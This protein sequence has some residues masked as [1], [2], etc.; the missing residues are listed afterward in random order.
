MNVG[1]TRSPLFISY[2][3]PGVSQV[4]TPTAP[5]HLSSPQWGEGIYFGTPNFTSFAEITGSDH[6]YSNTPL[7]WRYGSEQRS[8]DSTSSSGAGNAGDGAGHAGGADGL[9]APG[10][11]NGGKKKGRHH[12]SAPDLKMQADI[13]VQS[14]IGKYGI[15]ENDHPAVKYV[16]ELASRLFGDDKGV[17]VL[18]TKH[19]DEINS[20][21]LPNRTI[22]LTDRMIQFCEFEE[23]LEYVLS[24][25]GRHIVKK[26]FEQNMELE[27]AAE[28]N[29]SRLLPSVN[30]ELALLGQR[31]REEW[32]SDLG[33]G[34]DM[35]RKRL[36]PYGE[37]VFLMR[38]LKM[39]QGEDDYDMDHGSS[40]DR[41]L[42]FGM[43]ARLYDMAALTTDLT[44]IPEDIRC[45]PLGPARSDF[46]VLVS[47]GVFEAGTRYEIATERH[48]RA[49]EAG[50]ATLLAALPLISD[51][52]EKRYEEGHSSSL[53][54]MLIKEDKIVLER[55]IKKIKLEIDHK[56]PETSTR[57]RTQILVAA[58]IFGSG[59]FIFESSDPRHP[60][61]ALT[62]EFIGTLDS[63]EDFQAFARIVRPETFEKL[64]LYIS[65]DGISEDPKVP[66]YSLKNIVMTALES[67]LFDAGEE[68]LDVD[69][70]LAFCMEWVEHISKLA[71]DRGMIDLIKEKEIISLIL[72][73]KENL[74]KGQEEWAY[75]KKVAEKTSITRIDLKWA[76]FKIYRKRI[77]LDDIPI[78][79]K[80]GAK[81]EEKLIEILGE[82]EDKKYNVQIEQLPGIYNKYIVKKGGIK[83]DVCCM[84]FSDKTFDA[85]VDAI[86]SRKKEDFIAAFMALSIDLMDTVDEH[87]ADFKVNYFLE[88]L[89]ENY[90]FDLSNKE[91]L[92]FLHLIGRFVPDAFLAQRLRKSLLGKMMDKL[93]AAEKFD[94]LFSDR[95]FAPSI[96]FGT[97]KDHMDK[98][99]NTL[100][101]ISR[102][103][104]IVEKV[105]DAPLSA[106]YGKLVVMDSLMEKEKDK[107]RLFEVMMK[108]RESELE[109][110]ESLFANKKREYRI[111]WNSK[112]RSVVVA[113][114]QTDDDLKG[115]YMLDAVAV[116]AVVRKI[117]TGKGGLLTTEDG[118]EWLLEY[119]FKNIVKKGES[120]L[121]DILKTSLGELM[122]RADIET[123]FFAIAPVIEPRILKPPPES[124]AWSDILEEDEDICCDIS[125][126]ME[127]YD[128]E[129]S[130]RIVHEEEG[131]PHAKRKYPVRILELIGEEKPEAAKE[132]IS[133]L[134]LTVEMAG[135]LGSPGVRFLQILGQFVRIPPEYEKEFG[136]AYDGMEGQTKLTAHLV[137]KREWPQ[138]ADEIAEIGAPIG[139]GSLMTTF[140]AMNRDGRE[141]VIKVLNPN[142]EY[143]LEIIYKMLE[144]VIRALARSKGGGY[145]MAKG[146][147]KDI[148]QWIK[149]DIRFEG[150]LE[151]DKIFY[152][153]NNGFKPEGFSYSIKVPRSYGPENR[154][155]KREEFIAGA[156]LTQLDALKAAGHD[157]KEITS[158]LI[159]NYWEQLQKGVVHSDV[160][161]GNFR[162]TPDKQVAILDRN[163]FIELDERDRAFMM[164]FLG[165]S[166]SPDELCKTI[167]EYLGIESSIAAK[168]RTKLTELAE[169]GTDAL[170]Q[171][172]DIV[173][174]LKENGATVPL[175][176]TLL[177]KNLNGLA[178]LA[179]SAGFSDL[180]EAFLW[181]MQKQANPGSDQS[182]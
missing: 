107:C 70:Y 87:H 9:G 175:K 33:G 82:P 90:S 47:E 73:G 37:K 145:E 67:D 46:T 36:N 116:H 143:H 20:V 64:G 2:L 91:D 161:P 7:F 96:P 25:E 157:L 101:D 57:E 85:L 98:N 29:G 11:V 104:D 24:H 154:Y 155:F 113:M 35:S 146:T 149:Q 132:E 127:E 171:A 166:V 16:N 45:T 74:G 89:F 66:S 39:E 27:E 40:I 56:F 182:R 167:A 17:K 50:F 53:N 137:L 76:E 77:A 55:M 110:K 81:L 169:S 119:F 48:G 10:G 123:L 23:E 4:V 79:K 43:M 121:A 153:Q 18:I 51:R 44:P 63:A 126:I 103:Q 147:L 134:G 124:V 173:I 150:F 83:F 94:L 141:E 6:V 106:S 105:L 32:E 151:R 95:R 108:S 22:L 30:R 100:E 14:I 75:L 168:V 172:G 128:S 15:Y 58:I 111:D 78:S 170:E 12:S 136:K 31:R 118:R 139:G 38:L 41:I 115:L 88:E 142:A 93:D 61:Y 21:A 28:Q 125:R 180:K 181:G 179:A 120:R 60:L 178:S 68:R 135:K 130:V 165:A 140:K 97:Q 19:W 80:I 52:L 160:H 144:D 131:D 162:V 156:N 72:L 54:D 114:R 62:D 1:L 26:H 69:A 163:F 71:K 13:F 86:H 174:F 176:V 164:N 159:L 3:L 8:A 152:E 117:L 129:D 138:I 122:R 59:G 42:N 158:L 109:L 99:V 177:L 148:K 92:R 49:N 5:P 65:R 34:V 133:P 102:L 84:I 112:P